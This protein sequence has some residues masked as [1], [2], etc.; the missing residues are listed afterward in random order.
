[1]SKMNI[2][3]VAILSAQRTPIG[4][5]LGG[6]S[7]IKASE[8]GAIAIQASLKK[9]EIS[10]NNIDEV[11]MGHVVSANCGQ[12][13]AKQS[14]LLAKIPESV[15]CTA[16]NKVCASG[17]KAVTLGAQSILL[18]DNEIVVAGGMENMSQIPHY[19][20]LR[21]GIKFGNST[22]VDGLLKDGLTDTSN[23]QTMGQ[24]ADLCAS[25]FNISRE[26]QD[27]FAIDSYKKAA[28]AW[29]ENKFME[30]VTPVTIKHRKGDKV[31]STDEEFTN[32][33]FDKIPNLKPAFTKDG[34]VTAANASTLNDGAAALVLS[35]S[36]YA[37]DNNLTP[38]ANIISYADAS[39]E[40]KWFTTAPSL[41]LPK[42]LKKASLSIEDID[43]FEINEAFSVVALANQEKMG[44]SSKKLNIYGGS[45]ALGHPLGCSGARIL[46]TLAHALKNENGRYGAAV[47]CN[48]GGGASAVIIEN[49]NYKV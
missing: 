31:V 35:S 43:L 41:A 18:G 12:A 10:V 21:N 37:N 8:L 5:F 6:L 36:K 46:T 4:T 48:G 24:F 19:A 44:I 39:Q 38:L 42:A 7:S 11:F 14:A 23:G 34:T 22:F 13:P 3:K 26:A 27:T 1:M 32:V 28:K 16:I 33:F 45:V 2:N 40:P 15:P 30:E 17:L 49:P 29:S 25:T 9:A 47:I 20:Q